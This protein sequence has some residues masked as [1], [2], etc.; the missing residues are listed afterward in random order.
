[1]KF[2]TLERTTGLD[3]IHNRQSEAGLE[4]KS[5]NSESSTGYVWNFVVYTGKD[6]IYGQRHPGEQKKPSGVLDYQKNMGGV[7]RNDGQLQSYKLAQ[8]CLKK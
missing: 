1:M 6:T 8:E 3:S 7:D 2:P 4:W 5:T